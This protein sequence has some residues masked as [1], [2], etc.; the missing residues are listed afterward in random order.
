MRLR[1]TAISAL[2]ALSACA[3]GPDFH[4]PPAPDTQRYTREPLPA[5]TVAASGP[6]GGAQRFVSANTA[7]RAWW[8]AFGSN[9]LDRLVDEALQRSPTIDA[10]RSRLIAAQEDYRARAGETV[11]PSIDAGVSATRRKVDLASFGLANTTAPPPFTLYDA[12]VNV[13]YLLD[14]FGG[15]RRALDGM[16]AQVDYA[17]FEWDAARL[18]LAGNVVSATIRRAS[19]RR[20]LD[21]TRQ[22]EQAQARQLDIMAHRQM[23]GGVAELDVRAQRTLLEQTRAAIPPLAAQL[24][25]TEHRLAVLV[26]LPSARAHF[27]DIALDDLQLPDSLPVTLPSTLARE[28]PDI[29][30]SEALLHRASADVG[31]ATANLFPQ[32]SITASAGSERTHIRDIL[33]QFNVWSLGLS[34][35]QPIFR[36]GAL[37]AHRRA[38]QATYDA[39]RADYRETVLQ[40]LQQVADALQALQND[41]QALHARDAASREAQASLRIAGE[42]YAAGGISQFALVDAERQALEATLE[43]TKAQ[44]ARLADTAALYQSLGG[45]ML[46]ADDARVTP[47]RRARSSSPAQN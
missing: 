46:D 4:S 9:E 37:R 30:A 32:F 16:R 12:S 34:M 33:D 21:L 19:L 24:A 7:P 29:R 15:N 25:Q 20:Q 36:G 27:A 26:G 1:V 22:L 10:S 31:V 41:A 39:A 44:A 14:V 47:A 11:L 28:R 42:R 3:V 38:A 5:A 8:R 45:A 2:L 6:G 35:T 18:A 13:T 43:R 23:A 17:G 40:A